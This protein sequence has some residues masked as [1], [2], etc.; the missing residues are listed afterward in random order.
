MPSSAPT[1]LFPPLSLDYFKRLPCTHKLHSG[2]LKAYASCCVCLQARLEKLL[3]DADTFKD[4]PVHGAIA[5]YCSECRGCAPL[6]CPEADEALAL[7]LL[8]KSLD[9]PVFNITQSFNGCDPTPAIDEILLSA[10]QADQRPQSPPE[11]LRPSAPRK[12]I[13]IQERLPTRKHSPPRRQ[14]SPLRAGQHYSTIAS[15]SRT[16]PVLP[17]L[18]TVASGHD[19]QGPASL[20][21]PRS[22]PSSIIVQ[23]GSFKETE[24]LPT[25]SNILSKLY[26][27]W[28]RSHT[29]STPSASDQPQPISTRLARLKDLKIFR[30]IASRLN[31]PDLNSELKFEFNDEILTPSTSP[32]ALPSELIEERIEAMIA[33][34]GGSTTS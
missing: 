29:P 8:K 25:T 2:C 33:D 24:D 22:V 15:S 11:Q 30:S 9:Q 5:Y 31:R 28:S 20:D 10:K 6:I 13:T 27:R 7:A 34:A 32:Q 1:S 23:E 16:M 26:Q 19:H 4:I 3:D 12:H 18:A 21:S 17:L 14:I